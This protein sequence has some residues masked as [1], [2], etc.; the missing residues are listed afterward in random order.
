MT[1]KLLIVTTIAGA[2]EDFILPYVYHYRGLGWQ[3]DGVSVDITSN[4]ACVQAFNSVWDVPW[5]RNPLDPRNLLNAVPQIQNI[6]IQGSYDLVHVHT[7]VAA[8]VTRYAVSQLKIKQKP[9]VIYTA[10]GFH[11]HRQGN[12]I[13]NQIF[14]NLERLAGRWTDYLITINREDEAAA[15]QHHL[16]PSDRIFY[17][18]GIGLELDKYDRDGVTQAQVEAVRQELG[19]TKDDVLLLTV[20]EFTSNKRHRDQLLA[21]KQLN[22]PNVHLALAGDGDTRP[23]IEKLAQELGIQRQVHCLG[24]RYDIP[25]L[26]CASRSLLLT[27]QRE[28][29]PRSIMEAFCAATPVIG[30]KVRGI[31]DLLSDNCGLL[32]EV[33]DVAAL[34]Q[35]MKRMVDEP[36]LASELGANGRQKIAAYDVQKIIEQYSQ[37]YQQALGK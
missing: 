25:A 10:H 4:S 35:G 22:R 17:T 8:F 27:S 32:V 28:G 36:N 31:Q 5:S 9:Q 3:V 23:E 20:A 24:F 13:T 1:C 14:L 12:P 2:I 34:A 11:F 16:L 6:I 19:L 18:P 15:R 7:P 21:L 30:T 26:I 29:L 37:I 33:G